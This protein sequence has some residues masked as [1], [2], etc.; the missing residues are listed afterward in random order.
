M[1]AGPAWDFGHVGLVGK[2]RAGKDTAAAT[3]V[4]MGWQRVAFADPLRDMACAV[5]PY[6]E[7]NGNRGHSFLRLSAVVDALGWEKAKQYP[8]VRRFLQRLGSDGVRDHLGDGLWVAAAMSR[9]DV[10]TV[11]PDVRFPNE[12][13][14]I[15]AR[16]GIIVRIVRREHLTG[17]QAAHPSENALDELEPDATVCND[18]TIADLQAAI[19][20]LVTS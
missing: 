17:E 13:E 14:A 4:H 19:R 20:R 12:A 2:A 8:D 7:I 6:V 11:F 1:T 3:L 16:A 5:D 15:R 9:A 18:G 10:P